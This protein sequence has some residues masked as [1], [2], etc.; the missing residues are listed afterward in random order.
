MIADAQARLE[1]I[2]AAITSIAGKT[3]VAI[4]LPGLSLPPVL[5]TPGSELHSIEA[6]LREMVYRPGSR[7]GGLH[8]DSLPQPR[9]DLRTELMNG[10]PVSFSIH[11][12]TGGWAGAP[13]SAASTQE[14]IDH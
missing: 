10:F 1:R 2:A 14:G 7:L 11:R 3:P 9:H 13:G 5:H 12:C 8:P 6:Q 4:A